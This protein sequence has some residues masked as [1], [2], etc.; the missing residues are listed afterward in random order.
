[1]TYKEYLAWCN[2]RACDGCWSL[3]V[4]FVCGDIAKRLYKVP[5]WKR[6]KEWLKVKDTIE[7]DVVSV[8]NA[9]IQALKG[10]EG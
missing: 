9:K 6:K 4:A 1:M 5:F 7:T 8:I 2:E 10:G 3:Q